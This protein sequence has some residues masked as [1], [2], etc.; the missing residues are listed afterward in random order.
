MCDQTPRS[1]LR[2]WTAVRVAAWVLGVKHEA[3]VHTSPDDLV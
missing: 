2:G 3:A 1:S